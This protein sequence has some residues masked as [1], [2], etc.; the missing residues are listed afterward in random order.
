MFIDGQYQFVDSS[1]LLIN[2][3]C[4]PI[5]RWHLSVHDSWSLYMWAL[6]V[7]IHPGISMNRQFL[8]I[9]RQCMSIEGNCLP[10]DEHNLQGSSKRHVCL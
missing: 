4:L 7:C 1:R 8:S 3:Q 10:L 5:D 9:D 2:G 6:P